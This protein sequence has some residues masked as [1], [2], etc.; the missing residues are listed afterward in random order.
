MGLLGVQFH[1]AGPPTTSRDAAWTL[2]LFA[3]GVILFATG[4]GSALR[5]RWWRAHATS[6]LGRIVDHVSNPGRRRTAAPVIE[7]DAGGQRI[8]FCASSSRSAPY[9]PVGEATGV[10]Y[11]PTDPR[12]AT[13]ADVD[14]GFSWVMV[15]GLVVLGLFIVVVVG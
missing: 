6:A 2:A 3:L 4:A 5:R 13:L 7:F 8:T 11:D 1:Y 15:A 14:P 9:L 12:R 10:L